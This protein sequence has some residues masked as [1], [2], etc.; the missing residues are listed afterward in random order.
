MFFRIKIRL[1]K[2]LKQ[3]LYPLLPKALLLLSMSSPALNA[4]SVENNYLVGR[5]IHDITGPAAE[6]GL[7]G[8]ANPDQKSAGIHFRHWSRAY[9]IA[10][11]NTDK[12]VVFVSADAGALFQSVF[13][14]VINKLGEKYG[15]TY[16]ERNVILSATHTHAAAGGQSHYALYD[17]TILGF[18]Q[19]AYDAQVNGIVASIEKAHNDLKPGRILVNRGDLDNASYNRSIEAYNNNPSAEKNQYNSAIEKPMTVLKLLQGNNNE[20]GMISWFATHPNA[21][22]KDIKLLS[23]DNKGHAS[24]LFEKELKN[25]TYQGNNNFV[26]AFAISNAGDMSPNVNPD[27]EGRGPTSNRFENVRIIGERQ[28]EKAVELYNTASEQLTG[29]I[30]FSHRY[31]DMSSTVVSGDFTDGS[32]KTTCVAALGESFAAGTEDGR[33]PDLFSEGTTQAN[34]FFQFIGSMIVAPSQADL[35]CHAPKAVLLAQGKTSP[36]PWSP[37][38]LPLS[39][40]KIGQLGILAVPAEF[41]IMSG[42]RLMGTVESVLG[43]QLDYTVVAGL[44]NAYSGYVTTKEEYDMQ[45]YEGGSTHFGPWTLAAYQQSFYQLAA[46]MLPAG[47]TPAP[48]LNPVP[49]PAVEPIPRDLTGE[50]INFQTGVVHDQAPIFKQIGDVVQNANASYQ[51]G[52]SV[53]VKFW[54]GH[55]KNNLRTQGTF[56]E[57][58]RW[59][60]AS[61][62]VVATD[63]DW[64]TIYQ[65]KRIDGF[66]GTSHAILTWNIPANAAVGTYRIRHYG[67]RKKPWSGNIVGY[68]GTSRNFTVY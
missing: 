47:Q 55:P 66:W 62:E 30:E 38:V 52:Q 17:I 41:T 11:P 22:G 34:P 13:Q 2:T 56:M 65:W 37:E 64:Q 43:Q 46:A 4:W 3:T 32:Q 40:H 59:N 63:N 31:V 45:H 6:V 19:Q 15:D 48:G 14:G 27:S 35:A 24:Y 53:V 10:D 49:F 68:T 60:G 21:M 16:T 1:K 23:G 44:S 9:V 8:Y 12:R 25:S 67:D 50:T 36:Y 57:V 54:S 7:M 61:W 18:I 39:L 29:S 42:R 26:A 20:V 51:K 5:G 58:Q 28:Y 33:G